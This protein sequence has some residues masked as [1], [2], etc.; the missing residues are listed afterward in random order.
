M[1]T[2]FFL[3]PLIFFPFLNDIWV[4]PKATIF[5]F[6]IPLFIYRGRFLFKKE[7]IPVY[8]WIFLFFVYTI[9]SPSKILSFF[10]NYRY[11]FHG[12]LSTFSGFCIFLL[13]KE[14]NLQKTKKIFNYF[15]LSLGISSILGFV[16]QYPQRISATFGNPNFFGGVLSMTIPFVFYLSLSERRYIAFSFIFLLSLFFTLSRASWVGTFA[17]IL[18]LFVFLKNKKVL[19]IF[20]V[21]SLILAFFILI[22]SFSNFQEILKRFLSIFNLKEADI[23]SRFEG[24]L[25]SIEILKKHPVFGKGPETFLLFFRAYAPVSFVRKTG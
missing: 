12:F 22:F 3:I 25:A 14:M 11:Y 6:S 16:F 5:W 4:L 13:V 10:G 21:A 8:L 24:Y 18:S 7:E 1:R 15:L 2:I 19:K 20:L 9:F 23:V 17:G